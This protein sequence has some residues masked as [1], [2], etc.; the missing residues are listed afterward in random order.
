[1]DVDQ[2]CLFRDNPEY[3]AFVEKFTPKK[4]TDDCYTPPLVYD[5][6]KN[7]ACAEYGIA[8]DSIVR[9]FYPGGD[10]ENFKYPRGCTVLDNPPFS[11]LSRICRFYLERG[12]SF[13]LFA[14][15]LTAFSAGDIVTRLNHVICDAA[16]TYD[17]GAVVNTSFV[18][19]YEKDIVAQTSPSLG[20]AISEAM[21]RIKGEAKRT[22]PK[23]DYPDHVLTAAMM[24]RYSKRGVEFKVHRG[25]CVAIS[26][27]DAQK[28]QK[29]IFGG[30]LLLS[31][32]AAA[33][34]A[35][36]EKAAAEKAAAEKAAAEKAA[37]RTWKLSAR[38][39]KIIKS[40]GERM[41]GADNG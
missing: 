24:Q 8:P 6:V 5:A 34:K 10:F 11:I 41:D 1:M 27:L 16:I 4:T 32:R 26:A 22:I 13:F 40:L 18:T 2:L 33:E 39:C 3:D 7:W 37:D 15:G 14:P 17:N 25:E 31:E 9:P 23:Y 35:A 36:A 38:E 12:I 30:G 19:N 20:K 21:A 29:K 28:K